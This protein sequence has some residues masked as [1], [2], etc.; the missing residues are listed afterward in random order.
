MKNLCL[1][2]GLCLFMV[3]LTACGANQPAKEPAQQVVMDN[4]ETAQDKPPAENDKETAET[5]E[6]APAEATHLTAVEE[7]AAEVLLETPADLHEAEAPGL[8]VPPVTE[9]TEPEP[10]A[11]APVQ[12]AVR[13]QIA[14]DT[15]GTVWLDRAYPWS[16]GLTAWQALA[17][18]AED[19]GLFVDAEGRGTMVY[20]R[21]IG[22]L[23]EFD[24]GAMSGWLYEVNGVQPTVSAGAYVLQ[25]GDRLQWLYKDRL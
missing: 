8:V 9:L 7:D 23:Y 4:Q 22:D 24:R 21:G 5:K 20:V 13:V 19:A 12:Q 10:P 1:I 16:E 15:T 14:D 2:I 3:G 11:T 17:Q 18:A 25:A 6:G